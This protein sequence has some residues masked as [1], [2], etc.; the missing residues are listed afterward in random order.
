MKDIKIFA[1]FGLTAFKIS[2]NI[3]C[4]LLTYIHAMQNR[5]NFEQLLYPNMAVKFKRVFE[6]NLLV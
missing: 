1:K 3:Y 2:S 4:L 6:L 5:Q